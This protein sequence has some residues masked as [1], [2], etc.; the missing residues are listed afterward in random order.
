MPHERGEGE[1]RVARKLVPHRR[2]T[3][4]EIEGHE[5]RPATNCSREIQIKLKSIALPGD[6]WASSP[7]RPVQVC[8]AT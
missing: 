7:R 5:I 3:L 6:F 8:V 4:R 1:L 2:E